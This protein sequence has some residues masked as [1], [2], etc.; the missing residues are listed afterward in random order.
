MP[1]IKPE[2]DEEFLLPE[3]N[4][5]EIREKPPKK[6]RMVECDICHKEQ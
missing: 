6:R 4:D 3:S 1:K 2:V 5:A